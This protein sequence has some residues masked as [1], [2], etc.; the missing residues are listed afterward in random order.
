VV[1]EKAH[2]FRLCLFLVF[3]PLSSADEFKVHG[4]DWKAVLSNALE[5]AQA[6]VVAEVARGDRF[7]IVGS[8]YGQLPIG[9]ELLFAYCDQ[10]LMIGSTQQ[11]LDDLVSGA[12]VVDVPV[13]QEDVIE[14]PDGRTFDDYSPPVSGDRYLL[15][16]WRLD[17]PRWGFVRQTVGDFL[18]LRKDKVFRSTFAKVGDT[19]HSLWMPLLPEATANSLIGFVKE[20]TK[21]RLE[22]LQ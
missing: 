1:N 9:Q 21:R 14:I 3:S 5:K 7:T 6:V 11:H 19:T 22:G 10:I 8:L 4:E 20:Q 15:V 2:I 12:P 16:L 18:L 17:S 13:R